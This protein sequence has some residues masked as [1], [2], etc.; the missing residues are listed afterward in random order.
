MESPE[1]LYEQFSHIDN[2][3][4]IAYE[5]LYYN[6]LVL[7]LKGDVKKIEYNSTDQET[8]INQFNFGRPVPGMIYTFYYMPLELLVI[9]DLKRQKEFI[10]YAPL[11]FCTSAIPT[12]MSGINLNMLPKPERLKFFKEYYIVYKEFFTKVEEKTENNQIAINKQFLEKSLMRRSQEIIK[13][14]SKRQSA[15][16]NYGYRKYDMKKI[17]Q[18]RM[19]EFEEWPYIPFFDPKAAFKK[20]NM[21]QIHDIYYRSK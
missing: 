11:M 20:M 2:I 3:S 14:F 1:F 10:D 17:K 18:R 8:L 9:E 13:A 5:R 21:K 4:D 6:Y 16:F 15:N 12:H 7:N 19:I